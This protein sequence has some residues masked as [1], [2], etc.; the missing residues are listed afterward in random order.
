M[1]ETD[2]VT[3]LEIAVIGMSGRFPGAK[4]LHEFWEILKNGMEPLCFYTEEEIENSGIE[5]A[6]FNLSNYIKAGGGRLE[7]IEYFDA[8]FFDYVPNEAMVMDPQMRIFH[9]CA[10]E[11]LENAGYNPHS[12]QK[13]IG[14]YAGVSSSTHWEN[15]VAQS[16]KAQETGIFVTSLLAN[17][18]FLSTRVAY[19]LNLKGPTF[20]LQSA[21]STSLAAVDQA[22]R[23]ILTG[24]C[25][26]ALAGGVSISAVRR[27]GYIYKEGMLRS[28]DGH[29]RAFDAKA[30]GAVHGE[31]IG[32]VLLKLLE[33][34]IADGDFIHAVI[35]GSAVN[36]D[37]Y[38]KVGYA[39]PSIEGQAEVIRAALLMA[40]IPP[41]TI[42]YVEA[43]G[44]C[45]PL[46]DP[47]E[48]E[49]LKQGLGTNKTGFCRI[50]SIKTN[51]GHLDAAAG[52]AAF[53]KA[54]LALKHR[55][56][57]PS[58]NF[59]TPNPKIN[60]ETTPFIVNTTLTGWN[61]DTHP[62]RAGINS[63]GIGGT[64]VHI[65][66]E[67]S[68]QFRGQRTEDRGQS[69][70]RGG[71]SPPDQSRKYQLILLS[72][73]TPTALETMKEN[74]SAYLKKNPGINLDNVAYTLQVGRKSLPYRWMAI[75]PGVKETIAALTS[76]GGGE[77]H[78]VSPG[79]EHPTLEKPSQ[80]PGPNKD[81]LT[82]IGRL[83]LHGH[84]IEWG[85]FYAREK[86]QRIPLPTYPFERQR[87]WLDETGLTGKSK[88]KASAPKPG[89][90][91]PDREKV[92]PHY[93]RPQLPTP[94]QP[95][96]TDTQRILVQ[97]WKTRFG[98]D[99]I[100]VQDDF[101]QLGGDSLKAVTIISDLHKQLKV[102][103][104]LPVFFSNLTIEKLAQYVD[105]SGTGS[106]TSI[107][108]VEVQDYYV[109]S[110][111][112]RRLYVLQQLDKESTAYNVTQAVVIEG[113]LDK[114]K[115][116]AV[117]QYMVQR[118][119]CFR[120]SFILV[121][122]EPVQRV[123]PPADIDFT[124]EYYDLA[125]EEVGPGGQI[126]D[127]FHGHSPKNQELKAKSC[128]H[129]FIRPFD[130]SLA[131]LLRLGIIELPHPPAPPGHHPSQEGKEQ[132]YILVVDQHHIISDGS[133]SLVFVNE[134]AALYEGKN[135]PLP[136]VQ[137]KDY[138][139]W[140][141]RPHQQAALEK[142]KNY[143][144]Q[145]FQ[146][147]IPV[148][149]LPL[150]YPRPEVQ[151]FEGTTLRFDISK[152]ET[153][154]VKNLAAEQ[155]TTLFALLLA[156]FS[157]LLS[158]I[159]TQEDIVTG[160]P[161]AGR[162]H[163][164]LEAIIG[165]FV[166]TLALRNYPGGELQFVD[167]LRQIKEN[168]LKAF[169]NQ[170]YP[171]E[172]LVEQLPVNRVVSRNPLFDVVFVMQNFAAGKPGKTKTQMKLKPYQYET[173]TAKFDLTL[174]A[175]E[176]KEKLLFILEYCTKLFKTETIKR[177][178]DYFKKI[179]KAIIEN[180]EQKIAKIEIL[181]TEEKNRL[182]FE[183]N[184]TNADYPQD[185]TLHELF[186]EQAEQTP[187]YIALVGRSEGTRALAPL[188]DFIS[189][190]YN[191]LNKKS[192]QLAHLLIEKGVRP[193]TL[194]AVMLERSVEMIVSILGILKAGGAY[195]PIDPQYPEERVNYMLKDSRVKILV[196]NSNIF[197]DNKIVNCQLSIVNAQLNSPLERGAPKGRGVSKSSTCQVS[198]AN[199][200]YVIYTS[201]TTGKPKGSLIKHSNVVRL[202]FN[203][204]F[205]FDFSESDSWTLF[206]SVCFDFSV[207]EMYGALL[208]GG[209]LVIVPKMLSRD[210]QKFLQLLREKRVTILNQTPSAFYN[211][212]NL[213]FQQPK[214]E[215]CLRYIIF[216]G[217]AL[218]PT[219]LEQWRAAYPQTQLINMY[220][221]TETTVHVTCKEITSKEIK[222]NTSNIGQPI[223][224]LSIYLTDKH[225][226]LVPIGVP[227]ELLVG[228]EGVARG[229]LNQPELT[230]E[231]FLTVH[232]RSYKSY[233]SYISEEIYKSGDLARWL[234]NGELEYLG[235]IDQQ[236]KIRGFRIEL[237]E[238]ENQL[239]RHDQIKEAVVIP[240]ANESGEKY[241]CA[242]FVSHQALPVPGLR[243]YLSKKLPDYMIPA[244]FTP[245][246]KIPLTANGKI[247]R[248]ALP[249]PGIAITEE[250]LE[251]PGNQIQQRLIEIWQQVL[252][253]EKIGVNNNF[254]EIGGDSIK[255]IRISARLQKYG[256]KM[257]I[258]DLFLNP[259]VKQLSNYIK[260]T[261]RVIP[262]GPVEGE[263]P[264]TPIQH[265]FFQTFS[266]HYHHF[267]QAVMLY[268]QA[269]FD[270]S[271]IKKVYAKIVEHHDALRMVY[272]FDHAPS[273]EAVVLQ[274]N[275]GSDESGEGKLFDFDVF[276]Y[277]E[278]KPGD[279]G[280]LIREQANKIQAS[281]DLEKGPLVKLGLFRTFNGDHLLIAIHHLVIDGVSWRILLE[282][283]T[284]GYQ[285]L[286]AGKDIRFQDKTDSFQYWSQRLREY[287]NSND[288]LKESTYWKSIEVQ[289][290]PPLPGDFVLST[291]AEN[292]KFK[293]RESVS[294]KLTSQETEKLLKEVNRAY[295]TEINDVL[296]VALG[297]AVN[298]WCG[299]PKVL[300]NLEGHGRESII[301]DINITR[302]IGWYTTQFPV[303]L[304]MEKNRD[305]SYSIKAVKEMLR[306][307]PNKGIGYG[308][309]KYLT[310]A[311]KRAGLVFTHKPGISFNYLGQFGQE[312]NSGG[313]FT[314][315]SNLSMGNTI[316]PE[317][318]AAFP[319]DINGMIGQKGELV[320]GFSYNKYEYKKSTIEKL[321]DSYRSNLLKIIRHCTK[322][323][324]KELTPSDLTYSEFSIQELED[325]N[326]KIKNL[327]DV[328]S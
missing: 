14:L 208:Y 169:E 267:N 2:R 201:G 115:L 184:Q 157:L 216:G 55:Q 170:D 279:I 271:I 254:F 19:K 62:L 285:Q 188:S 176:A 252:G 104:P 71:V 263:L 125:A 96:Y 79:E 40:E 327:V 29:C 131:P 117:L 316:N 185:K 27:K 25:N 12:Y 144:L 31:G 269:G 114:E 42:T 266:T 187:D 210:T 296:L 85:D 324:D 95:P 81:A 98:Y 141:N 60:F 183:F 259:T 86:Q 49:A 274:R 280:T 136:R 270:D 229:Y 233:M 37:G 220:G 3:G 265:W 130:L 5:P 186:R 128:I 239:L 281:M 44:T 100:G 111:A 203:D 238:I 250:N 24:E 35:K 64:N 215:L 148:L 73:K 253:I 264:L 69:Q 143:W 103:I 294:L 72:A 256:L 28:A 291:S 78:T 118:H 155:G 124:V 151:S 8:V 197:G 328:E 101:L 195:L 231:K 290:I 83:W 43:N 120:T 249:K 20:I 198:P 160:T 173:K 257:E 97:T 225:L 309:L 70:G 59:D 105:Q 315:I 308:I 320:L 243:E 234:P 293:N 145:Q 277:K 221:I 53:I 146:D 140:L 77:T 135:L 66:L 13:K 180:P 196:N 158:K 26:M 295:G 248:K 289:D 48:I 122:T 161:I 76:L 34:A 232:N 22:C 227:G 178:I 278:A 38:R 52:A 211:L 110:P 314:Q 106:Y 310:P 325:L 306:R 206:H 127:A 82:R 133:S 317:L 129:S 214:R 246:E 156:A 245:L 45:T 275:R 17:S 301:A 39:A 21:C 109:L 318:E 88:I 307:V 159:S 213:E 286:Q 4:N 209:K 174:Q 230:A 84:E 260:K 292:N 164:D 223:P 240:K 175:V 94:Y 138:A 297:M 33:N 41:H 74:L 162:R 217:E 58:L 288:I 302:T 262:Q 65:V 242:Y 272:R 171:F 304:P 199:L 191:H 75:C 54:V 168:T 50:G 153:T 63:F 218:A 92:Y 67:E 112:Q 284:A 237:G 276:D 194:V 319:I 258:R 68:P 299:N 121:E 99:Q 190:T 154:A 298:D 172:E 57:P 142:Q 91:V 212:V 87:Y 313:E 255:A 23:G 326:S 132:K 251:A 321:V 126:L 150:D 119:E 80:D 305:L 226:N 32:I 90:E 102:E 273:R 241:L 177:V 123:H 236:V 6:L 228:G 300:V 224:T 311:E 166:N 9:E 181:P 268:R 56:I 147:E 51:V 204:R 1:T 192:H 189:I 200:A 46:G 287:A 261:D 193:D 167:F 165:M 322:K 108:P 137:Y 244:Y 10:W 323:E 219:R 36:N 107:P 312:H 182:L 16:G 93:P 282:D 303:V 152:E 163:A 205:Q 202:M 116:E 149:N 207:W 61:H 113:N 283:F 134:I 15:L 179:L 139:R 222:S 11:T 30:K 89:R 247:D 235:R 47:V 7:N 18:S